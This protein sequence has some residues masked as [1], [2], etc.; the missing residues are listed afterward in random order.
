[1]NKYLI[2]L[3]KYLLPSFI[4]CIMLLIMSHTTASASGET[5][6]DTHRGIW[7]SYTDFEEA[8]LYNKT[9]TQFR[10]KANKI[11]KK[12]KKYNFNAIYF[13]VRPFDDA[14]YPNSEFKWCTYMSDKPLSYDP[15]AI[16][17]EYANAYD[18]DFHAWINP[19]RIT[20]TKIYNPAKQKVTDRIVRGVMEIIQNYDVDGIHFDDYFYPSKKKGNQ[21]FKVKKRERKNNINKMVSSVYQAIKAYN[22]EIAF[23]ISPAG[24]V[25]YAESLG[26]DLETWLGEEGYVDYIVPQIYWSNNYISEGKKVKLFNDRLNE[27]M[28]I[29]TGNTPVYTGLALYKAGYQSSIDRGW[30][31]SRTNIEKQIN[32]SFKK[33]AQGYVMFTY[34]SL[35]L[36][37]AK[38]EM[39]FLKN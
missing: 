20:H 38:N 8:G 7:F 31:K 4:F 19:Y 22:P 10:K 33:G 18:I 2:R 24:T 1:M 21:F 39:K 11:F 16:M 13:H 12:I 29:G 34:K 25:A 6:A 23:G 37:D 26:C 36:P 27:W 14:V 17:I 15:L 3:I 32:R 28:S 35:Y 9:E 30:K 5:S